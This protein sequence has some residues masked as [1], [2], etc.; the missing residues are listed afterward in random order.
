MGK[1]DIVSFILREHPLSRNML[2]GGGGIWKSS[3]MRTRGGRGF[4]LLRTYTYAGCFGLGLAFWS[5]DDE[6]DILQRR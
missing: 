5:I 2:Q 4:G 1:E 3:L 6:Y